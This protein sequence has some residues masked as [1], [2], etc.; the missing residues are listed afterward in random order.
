MAVSEL[1]MKP[2][3]WERDGVTL[4]SVTSRISLTRGMPNVSKYLCKC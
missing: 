1:R 3:R 2:R 4:K